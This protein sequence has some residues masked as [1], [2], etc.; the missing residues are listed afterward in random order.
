MHAMDRNLK[1]ESAQTC[2]NRPATGICGNVP[3]R[4]SGKKF[5]GKEPGRCD[6]PSVDNLAILHW[7]TTTITGITLDPPTKNTKRTQFLITDKE[8]MGCRAVAQGSAVVPGTCGRFVYVFRDSRRVTT[9]GGPRHNPGLPTAFPNRILRSG[10][11]SHGYMLAHSPSTS[12][13]SRSSTVV[14]SFFSVSK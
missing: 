2:S 7:E 3:S 8:S 12:G 1:R 6:N 4:A 14:P 11:P 9:A 13:K 5:P 10:A